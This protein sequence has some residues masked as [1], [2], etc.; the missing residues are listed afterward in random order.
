MANCGN[1]SPS[2]S[3]RLKRTVRTACTGGVADSRTGSGL[4]GNTGSVFATEPTAPPACEVLAAAG[5]PTG[6]ADGQA[7]QERIAATPLTAVSFHT[8]VMR[9]TPAR[10]GATMVEPPSGIAKAMANARRQSH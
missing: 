7:N 2:W 1:G 10:V 9:A 4:A 3:T 5:G 6:L 8:M